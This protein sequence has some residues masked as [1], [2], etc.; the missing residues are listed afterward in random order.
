MEGNR[1]L[2]KHWCMR[3]ILILSSK[4]HMK[5]MPKREKARNKSLFQQTEGLLRN[6]KKESAVLAISSKIGHGET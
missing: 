5:N 3:S 1:Y 6:S 4:K 2:P